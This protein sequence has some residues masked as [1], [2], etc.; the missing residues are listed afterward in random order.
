MLL[1][2][3]HDISVLVFRDQASHRG[4]LLIDDLGSPAAET[5]LLINAIARWEAQLTAGG[6]IRAGSWGSKIAADD[7]A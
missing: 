2:K 7:K 5:A 1:T 4:V 6:F 3:D